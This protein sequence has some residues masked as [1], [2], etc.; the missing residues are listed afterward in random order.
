MAR[1]SRLPAGRS[2]MTGNTGIVTDF[3]KTRKFFHLPPG[4]TY[5]DGNSLGPLP[6]CLEE[7]FGRMLTGQWGDMLIGGWT[8]AGWMEQPEVTGDRIARL[9]GAPAG[10]IVVGDTLSIKVYQALA[11]ALALR[12]DHK[13]VLTD[14]G[15]FPSDLY[16][17]QGL[18]DSL[19]Q[20]HELRAV[21]PELVSEHVSDEVAVLM[22]TDVDY[23]TARRHDMRLLTDLAHQHG[24]LTLWDLAHSAG[25][26]EV[27]LNGTNA[28]FAV[29]C[30]YKFLNGGPGSPAFIYVSPSIQDQVTPALRGWLGHASPFE[31]ATAYRPVPGIGKM[32]VGTPP[33]LGLFALDVALDVWDLTTIGDVAAR[34]AELT[35]SFIDGVTREC[36]ELQLATP[37]NPELRGSQ[38]S[39]RHPDGRAI[40]Q[41]LI[42]GGVIG[43]FREPDIMRFGFAPLYNTDQCVETAIAKLNEAVGLRLRKPACRQTEA[44]SS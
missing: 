39:F 17:A 15:N 40:M 13:I 44:V 34:S 29:G 1:S 21:D 3:G 4:I 18:L 32:R 6:A 19:D 8:R 10:S 43:D 11:S 31:F 9:V 7:R 23:R 30:T 42:E 5:L 41:T 24:A 33:I 35:N 28:D 37:S 2:D 16:M 12:P 22:L 38:V 27:G 26:I 25:A 14:T 20:G 36:P